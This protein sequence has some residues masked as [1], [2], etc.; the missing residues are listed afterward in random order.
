MK[1]KS[2]ITCVLAPIV[3]ITPNYYLMQSL[4]FGWIFALGD[5]K[6][7]CDKYKDCFWEK[8]AFY[9]HIM[10]KKLFEITMFKL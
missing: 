10:R 6:G 4:F 8:M 9:Y 5:K 7:A 3:V 1:K 2:A